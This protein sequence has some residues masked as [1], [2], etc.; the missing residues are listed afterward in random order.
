MLSCVL[1]NIQKLPYGPTIWGTRFALLTPVVI[2]LYHISGKHLFSVVAVIFWAGMSF[3]I[4]EFLQKALLKEA[5]GYK[6]MLRFAFTHSKS[7]HMLSTQTQDIIEETEDAINSIITQFLN[8]A[9]HVSN[10]SSAIKRTAGATKE[11]EIDGEIRS[12]EVFVQA[13]SD[14]LDEIIQTIV[15]ISE[16]MMHVVTEIEQLQVHGMAI[17]NSMTEIDFIAKQTELLALNAAVEAAH[18][19]EAGKGFMVV[20]DEVRKLALTSADFNH[21]VQGEMRGI[22]QGLGVS[23]AKLEQVV[24]KDLTP[25]L[26]NKNK[27]QKC[28][29]ELLDQKS[30]VLNLLEQATSESDKT[31]QDI[32]AIVQELQ[33]QDR[34]RQRLEHVSKPLE[35]IS[36]QLKGIELNFVD[37]VHD[38]Q[39]DE[40]F[41]AKLSG[42]Y[43]MEKERQIYDNVV[44]NNSDPETDQNHEHIQHFDSIDEIE[45]AVPHGQFKEEPPHD[46]DDVLFFDEPAATETAEEPAIEGDIFTPEPEASNALEEQMHEHE[47]PELSAEEH[48]SQENEETNN[49]EEP[50][51]EQK[52]QQENG[53]LGDNVDLF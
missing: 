10:Q 14:M 20:A 16:S 21:K 40:A 26:I 37:R 51:P 39:R 12:T 43:T 22:S 19:G 25:L 5:K 35:E 28:I 45:K 48:S 2:Y 41:L 29:D 3:A 53:S 38:V 1:R 24:K 32:F 6:E 46:E 44:V 52:K 11:L 4:V 30:K 50:K 15:W 34:I 31:S 23:Y 13:I 9:G 17:T 7:T 49:S 36:T 42:S 33:F 8:I 27:I 47:H 18:A